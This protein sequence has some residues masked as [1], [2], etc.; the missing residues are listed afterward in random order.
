MVEN[1]APIP[2][3]SARRY[4][5]ILNHPIWLKLFLCHLGNV[6]HPSHWRMMVQEAHPRTSSGS[7]QCLASKK[8]HCFT[9]Q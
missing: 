3:Q 9:I 6:N 7:C 8:T 5:I 4:S 2:P 1:C